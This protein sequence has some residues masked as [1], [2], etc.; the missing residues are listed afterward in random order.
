MVKIH[1]NPKGAGHLLQTVVRRQF[2][3][4]QK[5]FLS[6]PLKMFVLFIQSVPMTI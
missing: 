6:A 3:P 2:H 5:Y 1:I 4:H